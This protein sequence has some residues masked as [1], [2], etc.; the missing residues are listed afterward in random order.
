[1]NPRGTDYHVKKLIEHLNKTFLIENT[2]IDRL[3]TR[4]GET[5]IRQ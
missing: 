1:M 4:I 5:P 3:L 2:L